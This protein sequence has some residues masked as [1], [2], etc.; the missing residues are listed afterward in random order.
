MLRW[1]TRAMCVCL[2]IS[3]C[4]GRRYVEMCN[5]GDVRVCSFRC[6]AGG[7]MWRWVTWSMCGCVFFCVQREE[8]CED[9]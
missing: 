9:V 5:V 2:F 8:V 6:A 7:G 3:V 4:S 1:V